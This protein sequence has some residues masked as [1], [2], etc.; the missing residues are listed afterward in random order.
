M[1]A[2]ASLKS[3]PVTDGTRIFCAWAPREPENAVENMIYSRAATKTRMAATAPMMGQL[4]RRGPSSYS[5]SSSSRSRR[6][7]GGLERLR[8]WT[9]SGSRTRLPTREMEAAVG[10]TWVL[11]TSS[12]SSWNPLTL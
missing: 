12:T 1:L 2:W 4:G 10:S 3:W 9:R 5:S 8:F 6:L 7:G 11:S